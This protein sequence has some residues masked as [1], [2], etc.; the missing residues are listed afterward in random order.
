M[1]PCI[2]PGYL[3]CPYFHLSSC[4]ILCAFFLPLFL[5]LNARLKH[6]QFFMK[7]GHFVPY[8]QNIITF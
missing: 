6:Y 3:F 1:L 2:I 8:Y 5:I 7:L 4:H